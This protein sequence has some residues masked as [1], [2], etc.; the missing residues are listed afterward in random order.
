M[1]HEGMTI[2]T[3]AAQVKHNS[4]LAASDDAPQQILVL[5]M[6]DM[7]VLAIKINRLGKINRKSSSYCWMITNR[8]GN[9][10]KSCYFNFVTIQFVGSRSSK[11]IQ[12]RDDLDHISRQKYAFNGN[13][14]T[15]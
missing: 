12:F 8:P 2:T 4:L 10:W 11:M 5:D 14:A 13:M 1:I 9:Q 3:Q 7:A 15:S 6:L